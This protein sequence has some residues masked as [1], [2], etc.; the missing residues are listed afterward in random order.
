MKGKRDGAHIDKLN[1]KIYEYWGH[2]TTIIET[3]HTHRVTINKLLSEKLPCL[4]QAKLHGQFP[5]TTYLRET[6]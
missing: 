3:S 2:S 5:Y 4:Q 1:C 6:T